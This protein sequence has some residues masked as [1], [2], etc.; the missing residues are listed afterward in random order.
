MFLADHQLVLSPSDLSAFLSC[1]HRT[2]LDLAVAHHVLTPPTR[3]DVFAQ[4]LR[5]RGLEHE[6]GYLE[7]LRGGGREVVDL[8]D[9]RGQAAEAATHQAMARGAAVIYQA[10]LSGEGWRG[11]ADV[12]VRVERPSALGPWSYE[13]HD[14]K[15][16]RETKGGTILQLSAYS[17]LLAALQ[18]VA[19]EYFHVVTPAPAPAGVGNAASGVESPA[20]TVETH[21]VDDYAAYYRRVRA[22]LLATIARG[23]EAVVNGTYPEPVEACELCRWWARCNGRRRGDDHLSFVAGLGRTHRAEFEAHGVAT[24]AAAA[25]LGLAALVA[26]A[27]SRR[28]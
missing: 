18:G 20:F 6:R 26:Y 8:A 17:H 27:L 25:A 11:Y 4:G 28:S 19:P 16:A 5:E 12:L 7:W 14:T 23:H 2:G 24:L 13:A 1:R 21:R 3:D 10:A 22:A 9:L 15:L